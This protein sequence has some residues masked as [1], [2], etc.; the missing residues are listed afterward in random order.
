MAN[1]PR[2]LGD[3][4]VGESQADPH[5]WAATFSGHA[6][7]ALGPWGLIAIGWNMWAS[8]VITP[9]LYFICWEGL[10]WT[11]AKRRT[12]PVF[13]DSILDTVAV[14][15]GCYAAALLGHGH[16][17]AAIWCWGAS[18][19]VMATGWRVRS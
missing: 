6:W 10:Q 7:I 18:V 16:Q 8:A 19:G 17:L 2:M 3:L 9:I 12:W 4:L 1:K 13:F 15:F 14:A 5:T 11:L